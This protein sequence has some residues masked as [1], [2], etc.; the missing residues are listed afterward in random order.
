MDLLLLH[1]K[2]VHLP[3]ALAVLMPLLSAGLLAAWW[4][5]LLPRRT[6]LVAVLLQALLV[7]SGFLAIETGEIDEERVERVVAEELIDAHADAAEAFVWGAGAILLLH[8]AAAGLRN[9]TTARSAAAAATV[10]T[11]LVL[12]LGYRVGEAGG[13]LVYRHGAANAYAAG[14]APVA[15]RQEDD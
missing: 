8:L 9:D 7:G 4:A 12:F 13:E 15:S 5:E 6:W 14:A 2:I 1:P 3:V 10:G 11:L